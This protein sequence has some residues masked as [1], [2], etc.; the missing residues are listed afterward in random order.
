MTSIVSMKHASALFLAMVY[1]SALLCLTCVF[2]H[3]A[4][5]VQYVMACVAPCVSLSGLF[6]EILSFLLLSLVTHSSCYLRADSF[7]L[8]VYHY[9][10]SWPTHFL[11]C[12]V[13]CL[14]IHHS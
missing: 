1:V 14:F 7:L 2:V 12:L 10:S 6:S 9:D 3:T 11:L 8:L 5:L 4:L 13:H